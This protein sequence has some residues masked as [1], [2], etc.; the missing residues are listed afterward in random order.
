V[1]QTEIST[2]QLPAGTYLLRWHDDAGEQT[3]RFTVQ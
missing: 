3:Q 2:A 1:F